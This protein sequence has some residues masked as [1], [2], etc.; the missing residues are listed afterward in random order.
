MI[1]FIILSDL[2][3]T[4]ATKQHLYKLTHVTKQESLAY[5]ESVSRYLG[6]LHTEARLSWSTNQIHRQ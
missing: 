1:L 6:S 4:Q 2:V 5:I 3:I